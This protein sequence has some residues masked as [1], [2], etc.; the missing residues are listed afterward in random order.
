VAQSTSIAASDAPPVLAARVALLD[1]LETLVK[2]VAV[3]VGERTES[4]AQFVDSKTALLALELRLEL[5]S[6]GERT[7]S[8]LFASRT[9]LSDPP[10]GVGQGAPSPD[11]VTMKSH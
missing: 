6:V 8:H 4:K 11:R 2:A 5:F 1:A 10:P 3:D 7:L 9:R